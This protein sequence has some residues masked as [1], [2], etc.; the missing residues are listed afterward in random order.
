MKLVYGTEDMAGRSISQGWSSQRNG[1]VGGG[2]AT[3]E[4]GGEQIAA[5][6][7]SRSSISPAQKTPG[8]AIQ[9]Q[10]LVE[11]AQATPPAC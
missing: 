4:A 11:L 9:H 1:A 5:G 10:A 2:S 6:G 7:A 3:G 8:R